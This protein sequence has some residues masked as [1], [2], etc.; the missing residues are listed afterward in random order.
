MA[1]PPAKASPLLGD[2]PTVLLAPSPPKARPLP[3]G[4]STGVF[5]PPENTSNLVI[6]RYE[7]AF[8]ENTRIDFQ[9]LYW[10]YYFSKATPN[11]LGVDIREISDSAGQVGRI[12]AFARGINV[13]TVDSYLS[14]VIT[15]ETERFRGST[16]Q[17]MGA[18]IKGEG[19][20]A[21]VGGTGHFAMARGV[22]RRTVYE[23]KGEYEVQELSIDA[24]CCMKL[25]SPEKTG[26][27]GGSGGSVRDITEKPQRLHS[28]S[29]R[30]EAVI[31]SF[32]FSYFD[33][34]LKKQTVG[35]WGGGPSRAITTKI[36]MGPS[37]VVT[38]VSG[39]VGKIHGHTVI[40]SLKIVTN[41]KT[42]GPFG[43]PR[44]DG[45]G[46]NKPFSSAVPKGKSIVGF[47]G[48]S[49]T[50]IDSIGFYVA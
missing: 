37:E 26:S 45:E 13:Q 24:I 15:F 39:T 4:G 2:R 32:G 12:V 1:T 33:Q 18:S 48:C 44:F 22:I 47:F 21:I 11:Q 27:F 10:R 36:E 28:V 14:F 6:T 25:S 46:N 23:A 7:G 16:L 34:T 17:V 9:K 19:E 5:M 20:W 49:G 35:P 29:I 31:D 40:T 41:R 42:Y 38:A 3:G 30:G 43:N 8:V 50:F